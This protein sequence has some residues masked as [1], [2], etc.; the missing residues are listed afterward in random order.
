MKVE[1]YVRLASANSLYPGASFVNLVVAGLVL[2][3]ASL[4]RGLVVFVF[5]LVNSA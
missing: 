1:C 5:V 4:G 2:A 3:R